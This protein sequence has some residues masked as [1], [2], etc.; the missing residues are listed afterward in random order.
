ML[1]DNTLCKN[2]DSSSK[3]HRISKEVSSSEKDACTNEDYDPCLPSKIIPFTPVFLNKSSA[4]NKGLADFFQNTKN[5]LKLSSVKNVEKDTSLK[6][7]RNIPTKQS[8]EDKND[9]V[10]PLNPTDDSLESSKEKAD[11]LN[12]T[13][14]GKYSKIQLVKVSCSTKYTILTRVL[15]NCKAVER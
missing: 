1:S 13:L 4:K 14:A 3:D 5:D 2:E 12:F 9:E 10:L 11:S 7:Q 6:H 8:G 15:L